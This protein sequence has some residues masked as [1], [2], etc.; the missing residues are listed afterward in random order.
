[1]ATIDVTNETFETTVSGE[2]IALVDCWA[3][4]CG[5]CRQFAP[6]FE[7]ASEEHPDVTFAK[8]DTDANQEVSAMLGIQ[9]IPTLLLF[10]DGILLFRH[11]GVVPGAAIADILK[12]ARELDM[13]EVRATVEEARREAGEQAGAGS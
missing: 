8:L 4:W 5:P 3:S 7:K 2:G 6:I 13:A 11:S 1:M 9:S 12:Q 10:R